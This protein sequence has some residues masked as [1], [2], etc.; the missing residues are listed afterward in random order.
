MRRGLRADFENLCPEAKQP[1][2]LAFSFFRFLEDFG[3]GHPPFPPGCTVT[4]KNKKPLLVEMC[5]EAGAV[6]LKPPGAWATAGVEAIR[7]KPTSR[8]HAA[9]C[10]AA[11]WTCTMARLPCLYPALKS[12]VFAGVWSW[13]RGPSSS[14]RG[15][16]AWSVCGKVLEG[17]VRLPS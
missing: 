10:T 1:F 17:G 2:R 11:W 3:R 8:R 4:I 7:L 9:S 12:L 15:A 14:L 16:G 13:S 5:A 6:W